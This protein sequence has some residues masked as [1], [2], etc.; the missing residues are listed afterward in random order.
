MSNIYDKVFLCENNLKIKNISSFATK[1]HHVPLRGFQIPSLF[2]CVRAHFV[3]IAH[4]FICKKFV[5]LN[6][7]L[8]N[9]IINFRK[10]MITFVWIFFGFSVVST[11]LIPLFFGMLKQSERTFTKKILCGILSIV[12]TFLMKLVESLT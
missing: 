10:L 4:P 11:A 3:P 12:D 1:L 5:L 2:A 9:V 6:I 7:K 8:F